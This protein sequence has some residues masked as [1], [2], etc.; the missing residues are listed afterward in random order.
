MAAPFIGWVEW[1]RQL[2]GHRRLLRGALRRMTRVMLAGAF[3]LWNDNLLEVKAQA[4][5]LHTARKG[6]AAALDR[7]QRFVLR[8]RNRAI[9]AAF[10]AWRD[11]TRG[12]KQLRYNLQKLMARWQRLQLAAP[13]YE[14]ADQ[15]DEVGPGRICSKCPSTHFSTSSLEL[16]PA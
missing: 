8:L 16:P 10:T 5:A 2:R 1:V 6:Q 15:V 7:A 14:W 12:Q 9:S 13:F 11:R 3:I 4:A